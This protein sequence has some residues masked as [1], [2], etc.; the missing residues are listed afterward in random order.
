M[1]PYHKDFIKNISL[2]NKIIELKT[3]EGLLWE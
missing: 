3:I 1:V 2:E